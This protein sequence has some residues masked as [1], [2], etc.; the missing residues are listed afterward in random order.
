LIATRF[1][2]AAPVDV[3]ELDR[4]MA[5]SG[6]TVL[7]GG[8]W[9][10]P[11]LTAGIREPAC[12]AD[13]RLLGFNRIQPVAGAIE[14]GAMVT[15]A[16]LIRAGATLGGASRLLALM[17]SGITGGAQLRNLGTVGG[18]ACYASP[19]SDVP[20]VLVA[21]QAMMQLRGPAGARE[22]AAEDF[23][24]GAFT[25]AIASDEVLTHITIPVD[26]GD[27]QLGYQKFKLCESSYP[28]AT[29]ACLLRLNPDGTVASARI[30]VGAVCPTPQVVP[31]DD[32]VVGSLPAEAATKLVE[33]VRDVCSEPY[34]DVLASADY[35]RSISGVIAKRALLL[36]GSAA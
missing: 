21:L 25:A 19:A 13:L 34:E 32:L 23:F 20:A 33:R 2:Y 1:H 16:Q 26:D 7:G 30:A 29:A 24:A 12:I 14:V 5:E 28:I 22:L 36:A 15:Y 27:L 3:Q 6:V 9:V 31:V 11:E 8:T 10:L 35:R 4:T 18:S 17:A